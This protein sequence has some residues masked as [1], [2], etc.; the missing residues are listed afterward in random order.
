MASAFFL[1]LGSHY[2]LNL[3]Y[4]AKLHDTMAFFQEKVAKV[5]FTAK[6]KAKSPVAVNN[7]N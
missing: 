4:H 5:S 2:V 3:S 6:S 1:L 7:I